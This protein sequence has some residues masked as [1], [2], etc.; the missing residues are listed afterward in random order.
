[1]PNSAIHCLR[2]T[3]A[4]AVVCASVLNETSA[5]GVDFESTAANV[6]LRRCIECHNATDP[7]GELDLTSRDKALAGGA[8]GAAVTPGDADASY[9]IDRVAV[10]EMPPEK[11]GKKHPLP[12]A[13]VQLLRDWVNAGAPWPDGRVLDPYERTTDV[14]AGRDWWSLQP[15]KHPQVPTVVDG[16]APQN[17]ID[18]FVFAQLHSQGMTQAPPAD[19]R[20]LIRRLYFDLIGLPPTADEVDAFLSDTSPQAYEKVVDRLLASPHFGERWARHWLD[21]ARFAE[22][23]GYERDAE[24][25]H[26]WKYRDWVINAFNADKPYDRFVLE[27]LA[28]DELPDRDESTVI[29]T[30]FIRLG[31]WDDEPNDAQEYKYE[32]LEDMVHATSTAFLGLTVKCA[33]CHD[34]KFDPIRHS[35]YYRM[36]AAFWA[37][38]VLGGSLGGPTKEKL[39]FDVLGWTDDTP[40]P[41]PI[42]LLKKG[43]V[44]RPGDAVTPGSLSC[45]P[46][47]EKKFSP[48]PKDSKT[49]QRRLQMAHWITD[50]NNPLTA[51]VIVNRLWQ[52]H[53]GEGLVRTPD[54]FGFNGAKPTHPELLD[55]LASELID[56][57][58]KLKPLHKQLVMSETY[59]QSS[60]HARQEEFAKRDLANQLLW[61]ANRRR[62]DAECLRDAI[63]LSSGQLDT[64]V[65]GPSFRAPISSEALEG[66]S[67]KSDAY[68]A[69]SPDEARRRSLYMFTKRGLIVPLMTT[70]DAC[71]TT[72]PTGQRDVTTVAPQALALLNNAWIHE[73]SGALAN[74]VITAASDPATR[75]DT[76]WRFAFGRLPS[77]D[78]R[79]FALMHLERQKANIDDNTG[80]RNIWASL[81]HVLLN[82]NEFMYL[83]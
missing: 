62:I 65:G 43:D 5:S 20:T 63:L 80:E 54:N 60:L 7:S 77:D 58:W 15:I 40:T 74:R 9:L 50:P 41:T 71:D 17:P 33:R 44:H 34:H 83:D 69:S 42:H 47:L 8:S 18:A 48:P 28:G 45:I 73:Q 59:R 37:G 52:H 11:N 35:D 53:F 55:W 57:G 70:F 25:P 76:A 75:I 12:A 78:E 36:A 24:K 38:P 66:L 67:M 82:T 30:G 29:A 27:Q 56:G 16:L 1:M 23:N 14:R 31:T 22:T 68:Q 64:K 72:V 13:E 21:L 4:V 32:R 26:A 49:S 10:G 3:L 2:S 6:F 39:G 81:C 46:A 51:R 79:L 61:H 19:K